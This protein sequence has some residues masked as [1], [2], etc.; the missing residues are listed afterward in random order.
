MCM[1]EF[2]EK[3]ATTKMM[4]NLY[5][6]HNI[7]DLGFKAVFNILDELKHSDISIL[8]SSFFYKVQESHDMN[9]EAD[10][11]VNMYKFGKFDPRVPVT[12]IQSK[13][14]MEL[15]RLEMFKNK[16]RF[17]MKGINDCFA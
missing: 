3:K 15:R 8:E 5:D 11:T 4:K 17:S 7:R 13:R 14:A 12:A 9:K 2:K 10:D 6:E 16:N 1:E